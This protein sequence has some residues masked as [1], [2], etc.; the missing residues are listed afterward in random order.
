MAPGPC[1]VVF[2]NI[3]AGGGR[4]AGAIGD[5]IAAWKPDVIGLSEFRG[6]PASTALAER[7]ARSG[8]PHQIATTD[9]RA[10]ARNALLLASRWPLRR[11]RVAGMPVLR[12][13]W[14]LAKIDA[15]APFT[16][17]LL[18][19]PNYTSPELKYPF[20][21][22]ILDIVGRWRL[23]P[24]LIGGDTNSGL[25]DLDEENPLGPGFHREYAFIAGM[26]E[27]GWADAFRHLHGERREYTW[28]S[29]QN[30]G[31]RLDHVFLSRHLAPHLT[32]CR[33]DWGTNPAEPDRR[34]G[35]SDHAAVV[36]DLLPRA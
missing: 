6:T 12:A 11:R 4:R 14:L 26:G 17:G 1:R 35:L 28:Y 19:A 15:P 2:W 5:Q 20:L 7:L 23:G 36:V 10:P 29:H 18:H 30:N 21:D 34:E 32:A 8:W 24:V 27:R 22:A 9:P 33:H 13:R 3:R 16:L 31:F 25:R